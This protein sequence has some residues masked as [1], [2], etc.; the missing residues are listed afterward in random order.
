MNGTTL[1]SNYQKTLEAAVPLSQQKQQQQPE[2]VKE[3]E[4]RSEQTQPAEDEASRTV[5]ASEEAAHEALDAHVNPILVVFGS[6]YWRTTV[7]VLLIWFTLIIIYF[8]LTLH[9][10]NLGGN[11]YVNS[12]VAGSLESISICISIL[13][14]L[15]VG[16]RRSLLGYMLLPG[17]SCLAI[18]LLPQGEHNQTG[19][20]ALATIGERWI[21]ESTFPNIY[22]LL[23]HSQVPDWSQQRHHSH[24]HGHAVSNHSAQ[25]WR[26]HG[27][28]GVGHCPDPC[29]IPMAS[30]KLSCMKSLSKGV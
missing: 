25:L 27:Q 14:V 10:N 30:G 13:I 29:A 12:A 5:A 24:L 18:N 7:L 26:R 21:V 3:K 20:I 8:G 16:I 9:L 6:K 28:P 17:I 1:P 4:P 2:K 11:I 23:F 19:V 15:K 22:T